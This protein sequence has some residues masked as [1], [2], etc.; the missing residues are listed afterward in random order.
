MCMYDVESQHGQDDAKPSPPLPQHPE[1][2]ALTAQRNMWALRND[3]KTQSQGPEGQ[4]EAL[5][6]AEGAGAGNAR[7]HC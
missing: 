1:T 6:E 7:D 2:R 3:R 5:T 4:P